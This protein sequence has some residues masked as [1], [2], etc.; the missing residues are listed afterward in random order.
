MHEIN[1]HMRKNAI[2]IV[3]WSEPL[4]IRC[5]VSFTQLRETVQCARKFRNVSLQAKEWTWVNCELI[6]ASHQNSE[7][8]FCAVWVASVIPVN[9]VLLQELNRLI[10]IE[11]LT[12]DI[13]IFLVLSPNFQGEGA[14]THF[15]SLRTP[16]KVVHCISC[17]TT[18]P[19]K[20]FQLIWQP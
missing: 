11:M 17:K 18:C 8:G 1:S 20:N 9:K 12:S 5:H 6:T 16:I 7:A 3:T 14:K 19:W 10:G 15:A 4:K 2:L 13:L